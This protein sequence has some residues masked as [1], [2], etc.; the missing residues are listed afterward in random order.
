MKM[1]SFAKFASKFRT[2]YLPR[3]GQ[4]ITDTVEANS[5]PDATHASAVDSE[6]SDLQMDIQEG[7]A[8][9]LE[10]ESAARLRADWMQSGRDESELEQLMSSKFSETLAAAEKVRPYVRKGLGVIASTLA[11]GLC[12]VFLVIGVRRPTEEDE[13][14]TVRLI[15]QH[16]KN[17][18]AQQAPEP[19][20]DIPPSG[21]NAGA[22][23]NDYGW[24]ADPEFARRMAELKTLPVEL[25]PLNPRVPVVV[26][27]PIV[28]D[29]SRAAVRVVPVDRPILIRGIPVDRLGIT[30]PV[31]ALPI[32]LVHDDPPPG[33]D[34]P[35]GPVVHDVE[36]EAM[37]QL[38]DEEMRIRWGLP[39]GRP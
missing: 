13:P 32:S 23:G 2:D 1:I 18:R 6:I 22:T 28:V 34:E 8:E 29:P 14:P 21:A 19:I 17:P 5:D 9:A 35:R 36:G 16:V 20:P 33:G 15:P 4:A 3:M 7:V 38:R 11:V 27:R 12:A 25:A 39:P 26:A 30:R 31:L 10:G 24:M 37:R